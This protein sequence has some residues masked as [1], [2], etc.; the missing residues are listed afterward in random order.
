MTRRP[1]SLPA[2]HERRILEGA[3][4]IAQPAA[5]P[6]PGYALAAAIRRLNAALAQLS[7]EQQAEVQRDWLDDFEALQAE[8]N[9][10][11]G[12]AS[13]LVVIQRWSEHWTRRLRVIR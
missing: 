2:P 11:P 1:D 5:T 6:S 9:S 3:A 13:E 7:P 12:R 8:R 10:V 4:G